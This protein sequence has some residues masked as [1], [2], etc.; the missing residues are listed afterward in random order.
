MPILLNIQHMISLL[1]VE[2]DLLL[3]Q[4]AWIIA[5]SNLNHPDIIQAKDV[6]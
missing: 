2:V 5:K 1:C 4:P 6:L 3:S